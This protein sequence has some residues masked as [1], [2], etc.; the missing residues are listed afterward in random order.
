MLI[1][2]QNFLRSC[3]RGKEHI[4]ARNP[5][6]SM[7]RVCGHKHATKAARKNPHNT[8][9]HQ[10]PEYPTIRRQSVWSQTF[11]QSCTSMP[12]IP[13]NPSTECV[14]T[15]MQPKVQEKIPT[16]LSFF[17]IKKH[18]KATAQHTKPTLELRKP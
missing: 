3:K 18:L 5:L 13:Y 8:P 14:V 6:Q 15:N 12:K 2:F 4:N 1:P 9:A 17:S 16:I 11:N 7:D 10:C